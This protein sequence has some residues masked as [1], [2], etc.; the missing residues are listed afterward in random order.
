[1]SLFENMLSELRTSKENEIAGLKDQVQAERSRANAAEARAERV[2]QSLAG[3]RSRADQ[4]REKVNELMTRAA[5]AEEA[6][7]GWAKADAARKERG[8]LH[9]LKAAWRGD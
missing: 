9:R 3:E 4:L 6:V 5:R 2:E 7:Q 8:L 1:M